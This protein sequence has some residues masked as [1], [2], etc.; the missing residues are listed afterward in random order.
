VYRYVDVWIGGNHLM[1]NRPLEPSPASN[2]RQTVTQSLPVQK[3]R[4]VFPFVRLRPLKPPEAPTGPLPA[5]DTPPYSALQCV[6][7]QSVQTRRLPDAR[8]PSVLS[9]PPPVYLL[10][11][12]PT[13]TTLQERVKY[14]HIP[15]A[16]KD[17]E[18][19]AAEA[20]LGC[21]ILIVIAVF[22]IVV[23]YYVASY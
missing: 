6:A 16:Y 4:C 7:I 20:L 21:A 23:L 9:Q 8:A 10:H 5:P 17:K 19:G 13:S 14:A 1:Q 2:N 15:S 3:A 18:I 12:K 22:V 11:T